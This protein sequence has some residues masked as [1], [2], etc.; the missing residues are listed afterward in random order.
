MCGLTVYH[1]EPTP[2]YTFVAP[3]G[4]AAP[5]SPIHGDFAVGGGRWCS[6]WVILPVMS[7]Q[8][9]VDATA[10]ALG[11]ARDMY[12]QAATATGLP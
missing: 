2:T 11:G 5:Q 8:G 3:D 12:G 10:T 4:R 1:P 9:L 7:L 6:W